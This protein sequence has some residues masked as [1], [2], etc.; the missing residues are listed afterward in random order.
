MPERDASHYSLDDEAVDRRARDRAVA[1]TPPAEQFPP[2]FEWSSADE[3]PAYT[4]YTA[5][6]TADALGVVERTVRRWIEDGKLSAE[7]VGGA[8]RIRLEDAQRVYSE[9]RS[10]YSVGR[11]S[12]EQRVQW[13]EAENERLWRL[14]ERVVAP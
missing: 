5:R 11:A 6:E 8:F 10:G 4:L 13:L 9:S 1:M 7:K 2:G 3:R 14:L 12:A